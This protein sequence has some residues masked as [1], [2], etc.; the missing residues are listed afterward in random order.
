MGHP[1]STVHFSHMQRTKHFRNFRM[2][3]GNAVIMVQSIRQALSL[4]VFTTPS[5]LEAV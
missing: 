3:C 1:L 5:L 4:A 2:S